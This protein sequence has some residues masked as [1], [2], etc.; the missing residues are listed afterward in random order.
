[1]ECLT[2][3]RSG[4]GRVVVAMAPPAGAVTWSV[5]GGGGG[6]GDAAEE[7]AA[8]AAHHLH[9]PAAAAADAPVPA[10]TVPRAARARRTGRLTGTH[11]DA[12]ILGVIHCVQ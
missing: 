8:Q 12:G 4:Q 3:G 10:N 1:M 7:E 6:G 9:E 11:A 5:V 2:R